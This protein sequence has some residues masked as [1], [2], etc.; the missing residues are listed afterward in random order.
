MSIPASVRGAAARSLPVRA[1]VRALPE[2]LAPLARPSAFSWP[3]VAAF[4]G[5]TSAKQLLSDARAFGGPFEGWVGA[6]I[7]SSAVF[8]A[9]FVLAR[10]VVLRGGR[11]GPFTVLAAYALAGGIRALA[12]G[13]AATAVG[14][15][16]DPDLVYRLAGFLSNMTLLGLLGYG[17]GRHDIHR[18][19]IV[20]LA[21]QRE[22]L[23]ALEQTLDDA[24]DRT[25]TELTAAVRAAIEPALRTLEAALAMTAAG[26]GAAPALALLDRLVDEEVRPL[27]RRLAGDEAPT[28]LPEPATA[29][30]LRARVPLPDRFAVADGIR[31]LGFSLLLPIL[32]LPTAIR[33][34]EGLQ[35]AVYAASTFV[36]PWLVLTAVQRILRGRMLPTIAGLIVIV[37]LHA[38]VV[39][40]GLPAA[41]ILGIPTP[42]ALAITG[43]IVAG[44]V[45]GAIAVAILVEVRRAASE[46][47]LA[48]VVGRLEVSTVILRRRVRLARRRLARLL[49][50]SLQGELYAAAL[51]LRETSEPSAADVDEV[52]SAIAA[53]LRHLD[54]PPPD[55][56]RTQATLD[57][58]AA[59]WEGLRTIKAS[60]ADAVAPVLA[61]DLDA[62]EAVAEVVHE[63][64]NNAIRHGG[65]T[66]VTIA[67]TVELPAEAG[68][69]AAFAPLPGMLVIR[70]TDDGSGWPIDARPGQGSAT[71]DELCTHWEH[72]SDAAGTIVLARVPFGPI[73][74]PEELPAGSMS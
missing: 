12:F 19:V 2:R 48:A 22:R 65:A 23:I 41:A 53:A 16:E 15:A 1:W 39:G 30:G 28:A 60:L 56:G 5:I 8:L 57:A 14:V 13:T 29:A 37:A 68:A 34:L 6:A 66:R 20:D 9:V 21:R 63:A 59:T 67:I 42:R 73:R 43:A 24:L 40:V 70:V 17:A 58:L 32:A 36:V 50:G 46:A 33:D 18:A 31:P 4:I 38:I 54:D 74:P 71:L 27:S 10:W 7:A 11:P 44:G 52:R 25:R 3:V 64:A 51:R 61:A 55:G 72:A 62:D 47:E 26:S 49:H 35:I 69:G 45:G